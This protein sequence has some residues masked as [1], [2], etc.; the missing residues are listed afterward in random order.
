MADVKARIARAKQRFGK[1]RHIWHDKQL[2]RNLRLR[3]YRASVCSIMTY[4]SEAWTLS[5]E[6][7]RALN[8]ANASMV[9]IITGRTPREEASDKWGGR[10][11][12]LIRW[13]RARRLQW[14]GHIMRMKMDRKLKQ[15]LFQMFQNRKQ[16]DLLMDIPNTGSWRE[17]KKYTD[18]RNY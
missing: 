18:D 13:I 11:F 12:N 5:E 8:G 4:G 6:V 17:L 2:H 9:C 15:A 3:L 7:M 10:A 14:V 16:G 1:M